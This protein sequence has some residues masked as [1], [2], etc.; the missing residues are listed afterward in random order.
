VSVVVNDKECPWNLAG[1]VKSEP[2]IAALDFHPC[3]S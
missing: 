3:A 2:R 1:C